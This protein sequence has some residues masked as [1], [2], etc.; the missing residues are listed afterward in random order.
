MG[1][2]VYRRALHVVNETDYTL[3]FV[4]FLEKKK[5]IEAGRCMLNSHSSLRSA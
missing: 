4:D 5:Y 2:E 1:D 3:N